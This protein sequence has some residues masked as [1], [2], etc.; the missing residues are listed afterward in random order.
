MVDRLLC[1]KACGMRYPVCGIEHIIQPLLLI[2]KNN[3]CGGSGFPLSRYPNGPLPYV[4][5]HITVNKNVLS[6]SLNKI[7]P[8]FLL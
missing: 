6:A 8:S 5:R 4:R 2:G 1:S 3:Q 7:F